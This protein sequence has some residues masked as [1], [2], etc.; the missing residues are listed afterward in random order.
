MH[1]HR[2]HSH[3][4]RMHTYAGITGI[5]D[6]Q[7]TQANAPMTHAKCACMHSPRM[8]SHP[9]HSHPMQ[10]HVYVHIM[11][12]KDLHITHANAC[13]TSMQK[14]T[15]RKME[16]VTIQSDPEFSYLICVFLMA[17]LVNNKGGLSN[18][19]TSTEIVVVMIISLLLLRQSITLSSS[20]APVN[21]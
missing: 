6:S 20:I 8:C 21:A 10:M 2:M 9:I 18:K 5:K 16:T 1:S 3:C 4:M 19:F 17:P 11:N 15:A 13:M 7:M 14:L 12:S